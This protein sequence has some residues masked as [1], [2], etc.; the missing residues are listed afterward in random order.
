MFEILTQF[1]FRH[2][3]WSDLFFYQSKANFLLYIDFGYFV[4]ADAISHKGLLT[5]PRHLIPSYLF[6]GRCLLCI[7]IVIRW[8][9]DRDSFLIVFFISCSRFYTK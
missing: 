4:Y 2:A 7:E 5:P 9:I 6:S 3:I 1:L 8:W